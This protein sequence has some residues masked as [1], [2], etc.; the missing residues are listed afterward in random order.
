MT[1]GDLAVAER[2]L[3]VCSRSY[4]IISI[5]A[6]PWLLFIILIPAVCAV[7][8]I[9]GIRARRR[10]MEISWQPRVLLLMGLITVTA[11]MVAAATSLH[12]VVFYEA[13]HPKSVNQ[14]VIIRLSLTHACV[15]FRQGILAAA[16]CFGLAIILPRGRNTPAQIGETERF[17]G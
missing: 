16:F 15:V 6:L 13:T 8:F 12:D 3:N 10:R 2:G 1:N 9:C 5:P 7:V 4:D 14:E 11:T 17:K